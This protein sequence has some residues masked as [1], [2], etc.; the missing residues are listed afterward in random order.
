MKPYAP[1]NGLPAI[2]SLNLAH[3]TT[4][5]ENVTPPIN[6]A[7]KV[8]NNTNMERSELPNT[9]YQPNAQLAKTPIQ[10][11]IAKSSGI[12]VISK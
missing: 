2:F 5:P 1:S 10:L 8:T 6:N 4:L 11:N 9:V 3:A 12:D 7:K